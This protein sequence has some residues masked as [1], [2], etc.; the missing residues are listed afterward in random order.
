VLVADFWRL[1]CPLPWPPPVL[2]AVRSAWPP[3]FA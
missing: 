3:R 1:G 2:T